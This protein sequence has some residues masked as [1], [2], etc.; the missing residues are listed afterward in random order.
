MRRSSSTIRRWG[1][2][3]A[4]VSG[5]ATMALSSGATAPGAVGPRDQAQHVV[6][7]IRIEQGG[8]KPARRVVRAR[9]EVG[10]RPRNPRGLQ[11]GELHGQG[12]AFRG[13]V[14]KA[15]APV[16][17]AFLLHHVALL[18]ELLE[19]AAQRL[20]GDLQHDQEI[21][22]LHAGVAVDEMQ[23][24]VVGPPEG[25]S[26]KHFIGIADEV[27]VGKE[28]EFDQ[29]PDRL[30]Q[31]GRRFGPR[32]G[33][34]VGGNNYVSHVDIFGFDCYSIRRVRETIF[35]RRRVVPGAVLRRSPEALSYWQH[36][37]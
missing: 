4:G 12:F 29:V 22:H 20:F 14:K 27:A 19:D 15:L 25:E 31:S 17:L 10:Q 3:S 13:D 32:W 1:A 23:D 2:L 33:C 36:Y 16:V 30:V 26:R 7:S 37:R 5:A 35:P 18:D 21:G 11:P 8:E 6:P 28:Q 24:A 9:A 34:A